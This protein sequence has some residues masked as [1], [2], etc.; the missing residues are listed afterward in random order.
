MVAALEPRALL[1][2]DW[3]ALAVVASAGCLHRGLSRSSHLERARSVGANLEKL[4]VAEE[5]PA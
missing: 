2:V 3:K 5:T 4:G 1:I